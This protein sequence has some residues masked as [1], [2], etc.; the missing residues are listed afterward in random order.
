MPIARHEVSLQAPIRA[1]A[2]DASS[3]LAVLDKAASLG[4]DVA[5]ENG[6]EARCLFASGPRDLVLAL[7]L[8]ARNRRIPMEDVLV[9]CEDDL[10]FL[11]RKLAEGCE[12]SG[13]RAALPSVL[14]G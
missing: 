6:E 10:A 3:A 4:L 9:D 12:T 8:W 1:L 14:F 2:R 11:E 7:V 13:E 5:E